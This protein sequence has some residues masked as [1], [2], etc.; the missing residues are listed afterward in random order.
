MF[1]QAQ[2][3]AGPGQAPAVSFPAPVV[4]DLNPRSNIASGVN[5]G[6][7]LGHE[8]TTT[9]DS[10]GGG[11]MPGANK[12][13]GFTS[14]VAALEIF[15]NVLRADAGADQTVQPG[16]TVT[17][18]GAG[19]TS[20]SG[21]SLTYT[22]TQIGGPTV[23]LSGTGATR[24][25]SAPSL[26]GG[27]TLT[28]QLSV[29][30]GSGT[31]TDTVTISVASYSNTASAGDGGTSSVSSLDVPIPPTA[32]AGDAAVLTSINSFNGVTAS[33]PAGWA[34]QGPYDCTQGNRMYV[35]TK[36]LTSG[37]ISAETVTITFSAA[38]CAVAAI[39]A[40]ATSNTTDPFGPV[41]G[42]GSKTTTA[43]T[44]STVRDN[45]KVVQ[46]QGQA[47]SGPGQAPAVSF[48]RGS[49]D[50]NPRSNRATNANVGVSLGHID[51]PST[52]SYGGGTLDGSSNDA[53]Y[54]SQSLA[55]EVR[56][57]AADT[58]EKFTE[59]GDGGTSS[60]SSLTVPIPAG[61]AA[62]YAAVMVSANNWNAVTA[63]AP[64]GWSLD[65]TFDVTSGNRLNVWRK[66]LTAAD[67]TNKSVTIT[68]STSTRCV[69]AM[70][71]YD[72]NGTP[73]PFGP[74]V[75]GNTN[76]ITAT[77]VTTTKTN[78]V[79]VQVQSQAFAGDGQAPA[80]S[81]SRGTTDVNPR[82]NIATGANVGVAIGHI[83]APTTGT[84]GGGTIAGASSAVN[85]SSQPLAFTIIGPQQL[86]ADAGDDQA[87][88]EPFTTV[89][90]DGSDSTSGNGNTLSYLWTQ[91]GGPEVALSGTG[92]VRTFEAP[93]SLNGATLTFQL[94]V[95][96]GAATSTA[97]TVQVQV[98]PHTIWTIAASGGAHADRP[99]RREVIES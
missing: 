53:G 85:Y 56:T 60:V 39:T 25:F 86:A 77:S 1:L 33:A 49:T 79:V 87:G 23:T 90:L 9:P 73:N 8:A 93:A 95:N 37:D 21:A 17:L 74:I 14:Q 13:T 34:Q 64:A 15:A 58:G 32:Q 97:D 68:F 6:L 61:A 72:V 31:D 43:Q 26:P 88:V 46:I 20:G 30:D 48:A 84:Y 40:V 5:V 81:F 38:T 78:S 94:R 55:I 27:A 70:Y 92:A 2:T 3:T 29:N 44:V 76:T 82:T 41:V 96:N 54:A 67:I 62:G 16:T 18:D 98:A 65:G 4:T 35:W 12:S 69:A 19:S 42:G 83:N 91:T 59:A 28:F 47:Y 36:V 11:T 99:I 50:E 63:S 66:V 52:G 10:Y 89:T 45:S 24:T 80:V 75:G 57:E 71:V 51:A 22:W 7:S